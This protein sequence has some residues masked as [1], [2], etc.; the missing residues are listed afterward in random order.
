MTKIIFEHGGLSYDAKYPEGIP[1]SIVITLTDGNVLDSGLVMFPSGHAKNKT[2][3]L[4]G[5]LR[6]KFL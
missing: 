5:I 3:D 6:N 4:R 1:S 2:A